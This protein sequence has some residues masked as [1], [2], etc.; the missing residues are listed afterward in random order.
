MRAEEELC[1]VKM[2]KFLHQTNFTHAISW[3][4]GDEPPDY[5]L[6]LNGTSYAVEITRI[7]E[8]VAIHGKPMSMRGVQQSQFDFI[9]AVERL[10]KRHNLLHGKYRVY[11]PRPIEDLKALKNDLTNKIFG[12]LEDTQ[13]FDSFPPRLL[14]K[15]G[16]QSCE[17]EKLAPQPD[18]I[19]GPPLV[20]G[21]RGGEVIDGACLAIQKALI[22]KRHKLRHIH[23]PKIIGLLDSYA[24]A[25]MRDFKECISRL[26]PDLADFYAVFLVENNNL[27]VLAS[28]NP[29]WL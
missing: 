7:V 15:K 28:Q 26:A 22:E 18:T 17:I 19:Y 2:D 8:T 9:K 4:P 6:D 12:Y 16:R 24:F 20:L 1:R 21:K 13:G 11:M 5:Y 3:R 10:A 29:D 14:F 25:D 23:L 27:L